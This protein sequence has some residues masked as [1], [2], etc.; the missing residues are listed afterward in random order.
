MANELKDKIAVR[1]IFGVNFNILLL[2]MVSLFTDWSSDM[3][4]SILPLF[5][6]S[7]GG[8]VLIIGII[9]GISNAS[10]NILKGFSGILADTKKLEKNRKALVT[11]GYSISNFTKP[12]IGLFPNW[13]V[14]L[15]LKFTDRVGKG[16]RTSPRDTMIADYT[17][18]K[19]SQKTRGKSFGFHRA[20]DTTGAILGPLTASILLFIGFTY[21]IIIILSIIPGIIA[22]LFLIFVKEVKRLDE[23]VQEK[24]D[25]KSMK[26]FLKLII[27]LGLI[28]F[29]SI[30]LAF[31]I[32]RA[33]DFIW[34]AFIP[35]FIVFTNV[36]YVI[37]ALISGSLSDKVGRKKVIVLGLSILLGVSI[38]MIFPYPINIGSMLL[39]FMTFLLF[40]I[41]LGIKDPVSRAYIADISGKRKK[42]TPYGL[43]YL[44]IGLVSL[45]ECILFGFLYETFSF[46]AAF[47][48][49]SILLIICIILFIFQDFNINFDE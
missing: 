40:G 2:G 12:L 23:S 22:I 19:E 29:A 34:T 9:E 24:M 4:G 43:Y 1:T 47:T 42:G 20:L 27:T 21:N 35:L 32:V 46:I 10:A 15:G 3:I 13:L 41:Y 5:I 18:K 37:F 6:L 36:L 31:L 25:R 45:P 39:I 28:E 48:F 26:K 30:D 11:V 44:F 17:E 8:N 16:I 14:T 38:L 33:S 7:I 49:S